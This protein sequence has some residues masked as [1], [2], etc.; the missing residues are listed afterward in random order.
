MNNRTKPFGYWTKFTIS[1]EKRENF[2]IFLSPR[3]IFFSKKNQKHFKSDFLCVLEDSELI[4]G[5][6]IF[7]IFRTKFLDFGS[8]WRPHRTFNQY[9]LL[10]V[11]SLPICYRSTTL[12]K[13]F[14]IAL[15]AA[16]IVQSC[17]Y[18]AKT[19]FLRFATIFGRGPYGQLFE[20]RFLNY[21]ITHSLW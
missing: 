19:P 8:L 20:F 17:R 16:A 21:P 2:E 6:N 12:S 18:L 3:W 14:V 15:L 1:S 4:W 5:K 10:V 7:S 9:I 13:D 11:I